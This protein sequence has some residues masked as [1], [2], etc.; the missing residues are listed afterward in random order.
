MS[1]SGEFA[2]ETE[3]RYKIMKIIHYFDNGETELEHFWICLKN[4]EAQVT[5]NYIVKQ[6]Y[7][8]T[9]LF[10][11]LFYKFFKITSQL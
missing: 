2:L 6:K 8:Y 10:N 5:T 7:L 4:Y 1:L 9:N 11:I 3:R